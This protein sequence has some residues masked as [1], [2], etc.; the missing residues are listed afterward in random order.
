MADQPLSG[1]YLGMPLSVD[2]ADG[3][4]QD[5]FRRCAGGAFSL[6]KCGACGLLRYPPSTGCPHCGAPRST[7]EAVEPRGAV[8]TYAE[9]AQAIQPAFR[10]HLPYMIVIVELDAQKGAP[11][12]DDGLRMTGNLMTPEGALAGPETIA[13]V[14]IGSRMRMVFRPV[15]E[16]FALPMWTPE[17]EDAGDARPARPWRYPE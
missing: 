1:D 7:W 11:G 13:R 8:Y 16:D 17:A 6:Q 2:A 10:D 15:G 12:A 5:F 4:N 9:V 14:G 3:P